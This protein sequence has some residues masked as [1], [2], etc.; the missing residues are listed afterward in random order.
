MEFRD[1]WQKVGEFEGQTFRTDRG[2]EFSYRYRKTY[3]VVSAGDVSV[4]RTNFEKVF[5]RIE[6]GEAGGTPIQGQR[7]ITPILSS[8]GIAPEKD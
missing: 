5:K 7:F 8:V 6:Q 2:E 3:V 4:P 1:V